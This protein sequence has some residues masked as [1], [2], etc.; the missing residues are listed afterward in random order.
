MITI[1]DEKITNS[2]RNTNDGLLR[3]QPIITN[4]AQFLGIIR[5]HPSLQHSVKRTVIRFINYLLIIISRYALIR[6]TSR[7]LHPRLDLH[8]QIITQSKV[9]ILPMARS[10]NI[11]NTRYVPLRNQHRSASAV[12]LRLIPRSNHTRRTHCSQIVQKTKIR[13]IQSSTQSQRPQILFPL[14]QPLSTYW[15]LF[16]L[17]ESSIQ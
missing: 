7:R 8:Y 6:I 1:N 13:S 16:F 3:E 15:Y 17:L 9:L 10:N 11:V 14:Q 5:L 4:I 12:R 2:D